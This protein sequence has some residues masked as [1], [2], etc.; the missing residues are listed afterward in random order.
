M[1]NRIFIS[2]PS[3][4]GNEHK[5]VNDCLDSN[6]ISSNGLYISLFEKEFAKYCGVKHAIATNNGTTALHLALVGLGLKPGDEVLIPTV[7]FIAT[8]NA[9]TYC[10]AKPVPVDV[11]PN[12][13]NLNPSEIQG[14]INSHTVGIIAVH[15]YGYP[16]RMKE[17]TDLA[18]KYNL[19][20]LEDA[21]ESHGAKYFGEKVGGLAD[22]ATFSF[23]GN[24]IITTG[25][26][27]M[28]TTNDDELAKKLVLYRGQGMDP[29]KKYWF[30]VIGFN[31]RMTNIQ[32]ALGLA[33]LEQINHIL[34]R[35]TEIS[36]RYFNLLQ[37]IEEVELPTHEISIDSVCWIFN[38][39]LKNKSIDYRDK[40]MV[41]MDQLG[42][43]T[44][45]IFYPMHWLPPYRSSLNFPIA[46]DWSSRGISLPTHCNLT[47]KDQERVVNSLAMSLAEIK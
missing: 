33:Q 5:Y 47:E 3:L 32:A 37:G 1:Q 44:R 41:R 10:G 26:G 25:E 11:L 46:D 35:R 4:L 45:P 18:K 36:Q 9:V 6:W 28:V 13:L 23:Y 7:T 34:C 29:N 15:L 27:G 19:W 38:I 24:K 14:K 30:P 20:V 17:I 8:A 2:E 16:A 21:A 12:N 43:E 42:I 40:I 39:F 22:A 31:Y